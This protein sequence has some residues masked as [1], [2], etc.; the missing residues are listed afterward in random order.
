MKTIVPRSKSPSQRLL[1]WLSSSPHPRTPRS[2]P[3]TTSTS[4][5][6]LQTGVRHDRFRPN[7]LQH[8]LLRL[9]QRVQRYQ[10]EHQRLWRNHDRTHPH[11]QRRFGA[12]LWSHCVAGGCG[13]D[14]LQ[15]CLVRPDGGL[16]PLTMPVNSP[17]YISSA[18]STP[19]LD[20][21]NLDFFHLQDDPGGYG[22]TYT[23]SFENLAVTGVPE[24]SSA[25]LLAWAQALSHCGA[26]T[27]VERKTVFLLE[28]FPSGRRFFVFRT[29]SEPGQL[30]CK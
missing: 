11:A 22:G 3:S 29:G 26:G 19:G 23:I 5:V 21:S 6:F 16:L 17:T 28:R 20:L 8:Y 13:W 9:R 14:V 25:V 1:H 12:D 18:G 10:S 2:A 30:F 4:M 24:P 27:A 7:R 15:L